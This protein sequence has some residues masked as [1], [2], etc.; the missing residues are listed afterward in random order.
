MIDVLVLN[1]NDPQST[2]FFVKSV[3]NFSI[4]RKILIVD[5]CSTDD[6]YEK[7]SAMSNK[8]IIVKKTDKNG[9]YGYGN[10]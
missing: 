10:N 2:I 5:N 9:G 1:Y 6:S 7:I 8:K 4:V 3:E